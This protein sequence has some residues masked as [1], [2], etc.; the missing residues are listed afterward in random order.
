MKSKILFEHNYILQTIAKIALDIYDQNNNKYPLLIP[1]MEGAN[2]FTNH[3]F[4]YLNQLHLN[5]SI[6]PIKVTSYQ[7]T[8]STGKLNWYIGFDEKVKNRNCILI[9][10]ILDTGTTTYYVLEELQKFSPASV[11]T[12]FLLEKTTRKKFDVQ[13]DY[14]GISFNS[15][16]V[17][18]FG[19]DYNEK[20]RDLNDIFV[21]DEHG[22]K[23]NLFGST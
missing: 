19:L 21:V 12:C 2:R 9:D 8:E 13:K 14:V 7:D 17:F 20:Y 18:G 10:D 4:Q 1:I 6:Y 5:Y 16:F 22:E 15:G 3:L 11:K 23:E